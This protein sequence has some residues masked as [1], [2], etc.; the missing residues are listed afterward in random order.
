MLGQCSG[1]AK[2]IAHFAG[3]ILQHDNHDLKHG[4]TRCYEK[5]MTAAQGDTEF[6]KRTS[7]KITLLNSVIL[8]DKLERANIRPTR[9]N[10]I[11]QVPS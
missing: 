11:K 2:T 9:I 8:F 5:Q 10:S 1:E 6:F 7:L 3:T 4:G